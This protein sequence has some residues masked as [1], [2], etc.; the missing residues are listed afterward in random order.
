M[1]IVF[2]KCF[3]QHILR[4]VA[5]LGNVVGNLE[6][7]LVIIVEQGLEGLYSIICVFVFSQ[8]KITFFSK[9]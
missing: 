2:V 7:A 5:I 4:E 6:D 9:Q 1:I 8:N 3:L